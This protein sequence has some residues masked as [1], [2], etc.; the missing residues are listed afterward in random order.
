MGYR[1][2]ANGGEMGALNRGVYTKDIF[3]KQET[4]NLSNLCGLGQQSAA[5]APR[6]VISMV[7]WEDAQIIG[8]EAAAMEPLGGR[9]N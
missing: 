3:C 6:S 7:G 1:Q 8:C 2:Q 4:G 5:R 9:S